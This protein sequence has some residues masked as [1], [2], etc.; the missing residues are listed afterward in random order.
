MLFVF[1][2]G[3]VTEMLLGWSKDLD[4]VSLANLFDHGLYIHIVVLQLPC[5]QKHILY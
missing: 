5:I 2:W 4:L 1:V 3:W